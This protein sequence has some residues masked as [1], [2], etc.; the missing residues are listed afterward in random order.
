MFPSERTVSSAWRSGAVICLTLIAVAVSYGSLS[1]Q[2]GLHIWQ[3][4]VLAALAYG[5]A[6]EMLFVGTL[7]AGGLPAAAALG[8]I[9]VNSRNFAYGLNVGT[10]TPGGWRTVLGAHL[11]NDETTAFSRTGA[12]T[13]ERWRRFSRLGT[14][15]LFCWVSGAVAGQLL[16]G[17][18]DTSTFGVDAAFPVILIA[19]I[20]P[21]LRRRPTLLTSLAAVT[22]S[23]LVTPVVPPGLATVCALIVLL[24]WAL[25]AAQSGSA[26]RSG[27]SSS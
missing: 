10:F 7:T 26:P 19:M 17:V 14:A 8:G 9:L 15:M 23:L 24:P 2:A 13:G 22:V 16:A 21:D 4:A 11:V 18:A 12:S 6:A 5:G 1:H 25:S 3:T 27:R 20:L